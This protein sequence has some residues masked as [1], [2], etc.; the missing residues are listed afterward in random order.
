MDEQPFTF[1][2][3]FGFTISGLG[4]VFPGRVRAGIASV[5]D[6]VEIDGEGGRFTAKIRNIEKDR[7]LIQQTVTDCD[8]GILVDQISDKKVEKL[9]HALG[10]QDRG[11]DSPEEID[12][13]AEFAEHGLIFPI[14]IRKCQSKKNFWRLFGFRK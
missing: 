9:L 11:L 4:L 7:K 8:I 5:G 2:S 6:E 13:K 10:Y 12:T 1:D 3:N 14:V